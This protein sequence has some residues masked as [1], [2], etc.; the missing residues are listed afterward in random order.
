MLSK[1]IRI[2]TMPLSTKL[3]PCGQKD[4]EEET[5]YYKIVWIPYLEGIRLTSQRGGRGKEAKLYLCPIHY[6]MPG[7]KYEME[8]VTDK[9]EGAEGF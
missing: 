4:C 3:K 6:G 2:P 1:T 5:Y 7:K 8:E 9:V